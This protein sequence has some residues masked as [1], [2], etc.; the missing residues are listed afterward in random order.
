VPL[1]E[2]TDAPETSCATD[3]HPPLHLERQPD[4]A[5][6]INIDLY[7]Y[8]LYRNLGKRKHEPTT[9]MTIHRHLSVSFK[10]FIVHM[11]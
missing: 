4:G 6:G 10:I 8:F 2:A 11:Y 5:A 9:S 3:A 1:Q 7:L